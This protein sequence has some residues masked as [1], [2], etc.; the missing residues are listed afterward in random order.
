[1]CWKKSTDLFFS[2]ALHI[3]Q[4]MDYKTLIDM[5]VTFVWQILVQNATQIRAVKWN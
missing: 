5:D 2:L 4:Q 3:I 1:M